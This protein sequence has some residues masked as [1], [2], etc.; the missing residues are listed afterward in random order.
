MNAELA[1]PSS[2]AP[3][4]WSQMAA[5]M[6]KQLVSGTSGTDNPLRLAEEFRALLGQAA[7]DGLI[8][9]LVP[10]TEWLP[11]EAHRRLLSLPWSDVLSTN[12]DTLLERAKA[13]LT[14]QTY[15]LVLTP[16]D[17]SRTRSPRIV[18]LHGTLPS[19]TPFIF[20]EED[21]RTYPVKFAPFVNLAQH[22][23]LEN[24]LL[25]LGFSGDDPNFL[26]WAGWVR[27][28]LGTSARKI[29]L[30]GVLNLSP[31]K[32][33]YLENLNVTPID[34][35]L[36][37]EGESDAKKKH[38]LATKLLLDSLHASKPKPVHV[39]NRSARIDEK[40]WRSQAPTERVSHLVADWKADRIAKPDWLISPFYERY[41][42]RQET[43]DSAQAALADFKKLSQELQG[44]LAAELAWRLDVSHYGVPEWASEVLTTVLG[45]K[46]VSLS[47]EE[48]LLIARLICYSAIEKRDAQEFE[49]LATLID[50][51]TGSS[52]EAS[53]WAA[54]LRGLWG[55][56]NLDIAAVV[57][58]LPGIV[59]S[60]PIWMLRRASL[61]CFSCD[62]KGAARLV[63]DALLEIRRRRTLDRRSIWL[64]SRE[65]WAQ[66]L[67]RALEFELRDEQYE[68]FEAF[69]EWPSRYKE[70][71][72]DPWDELNSL[73]HDARSDQDREQ[74]YT[75][76]EKTHF[77]P[78]SWTPR[79]ERDTHWVASWVSSPEWTIRRLADWVGLPFE[80]GHRDVL[81]SRLRRVMIDMPMRKDGASIWRVCT[82]I[83]SSDGDLINGWFRRLNVAAFPQSLVDEIIASL[84]KSIDYLSDTLSD[85]GDGYFVR[86]AKL[87]AMTELLSRLSVRS[88]QEVASKLFE[89]AIT[90]VKRGGNKH[91]WLYLPINHLITRSL[92]A[93][94][95]SKRGTFV[96]QMI[97]F[98]LPSESQLNGI[99]RDWPEF[100]DEF[101]SSS[102]ALERPTGDWDKRV[103]E[104]IDWV[105]KDAGDD[106]Y[107]AVSRLWL[108]HLKGVLTETERQGFAEALWSKR[109]SPSGLPED[110]NFYPGVFLQMPEP[111]SGMAV[112]AFDHD[113]I[114]PLL[115]GKE[116]PGTWESLAYIGS[117]ADSGRAKR[118]FSSSVALKL[119]KKAS[120]PSKT[121][122]VDGAYEAVVFG[123]LPIAELDD[124][125]AKRLWKISLADGATIALQFLPHLVKHDPGRQG[126]AVAR[127]KRLMNSRDFDV[128]HNSLLAV[129]QWALSEN[130]D[131]LP[132]SLVSS[133]TVL[134]ALRRDPGLFR[135]LAVCIDLLAAGRLCDEDVE[136]ISVGL[137]ELLIETNYDDWRQG[138][139]RT[140]T[141]TYVRANAFR[142]ARR[143]KA[144]GFESEAINDWIEAG[145]SDPVPE[146]RF[147]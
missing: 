120:K 136:N 75:R 133:V 124:A 21:Y 114:Q 3:P 11:G 56:D 76:E 146:V 57:N 37:V 143:L 63:R 50:G 53:A 13:D 2:K 97:N 61:Q 51:L 86:I 43:M 102:I 33:R 40:K 101:R 73:D 83:R 55:R 82:Y 64:L 66:F 4:L 34:L 134:V 105:R 7:L 91:W 36:L 32:R 52:S 35:S 27:D 29:R 139:F 117:E 85:E 131:T 106:R 115:K 118:P 42:L 62:I 74:R 39:W 141:L 119:I 147:A 142:L 145:K 45:D 122:I 107:R 98:P 6:E 47:S 77:D 68:R 9:D 104:L 88:E 72:A 12:W 127:L 137:A 58:A 96:T 69:E 128:A 80:S 94:P 31:A 17:I 16:E 99:E 48:R 65:A 112:P 26:A 95:K 103:A 126:E 28:Q 41:R 44:R 132:A 59:G 24:E 93:L 78:G 60:D 79:A 109:T 49:E 129:R 130:A 113:V 10:D 81:G 5:A 54:Y 19:H 38:K 25:L 90:L 116:K 15:D 18:K 140:S 70:L 84:C 92:S 22:V 67:W 123:F 30:A 100:A 8:R 1:S 23:L 144:A 20:A 87:G 46:N 14:E 138:D 135:A 108:L 111:K 110:T 121:R 71:H 125:A 89:L